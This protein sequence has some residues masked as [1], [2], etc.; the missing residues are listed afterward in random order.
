MF[1]LCL[2]IG[3]S[4]FLINESFIFH[5]GLNIECLLD[6]FPENK[7]NSERQQVRIHFAKTVNKQMWF[8]VN[9]CPEIVT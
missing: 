1:P 9:L 5:M 4:S 7:K 3:G 2:A 8:V 6:I